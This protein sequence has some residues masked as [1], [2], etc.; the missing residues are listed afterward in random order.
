MTPAHKAILRTLLYFDIFDHP[1]T[2]NELFELNGTNLSFGEFDHDLDELLA[3]QIIGYDSGYFFLGDGY[4]KIR[5]RI[6]KHDRA[7]KHDKI[8]HFVSGMISSYP[9]V[10]AVMVTGSLSKKSQSPKAD[11]DF[12]VITEP[13]RLWLCRTILMLFKKVFLLNSKKY[14]CINYFIDSVHLEIPEKN[15][16]TATELAYLQP[17]NNPDLFRKMIEANAWMKGFFPNW[18]IHNTDCQETRNTLLKRF[19]EAVIKGKI[20]DKLD[21]ALLNIHRKRSQRKFADLHQQLF[22]INFKTEKHVSKHHPN[23]FQHKIMN[24]Y[25]S[26]IAE[27]EMNHNVNLTM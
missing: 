15:I 9:F 5:E 3:S 22:P 20:G 17:M 13:G 8:A 1:L 21:T 16:F 25:E 7:V 14:F 12:F 6:E 24:H 19:L 26:K 18:T 10:R 11:I 27:F 2:K 23:G 4:Q